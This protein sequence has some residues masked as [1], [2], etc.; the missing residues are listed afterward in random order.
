MRTLLKKADLDAGARRTHANSGATRRRAASLAVS[1][2]VPR[3]TEAGPHAVERSERTFDRALA[4]RLNAIEAPRAAATLGCADNP[5]RTQQLLGFES[6]QG[7]VNRAP[8]DGPLREAF[9][10]IAYRGTS[11]FVLEPERGHEHSQFE[12]AER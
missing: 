10:F 4:G 3:E 9:D 12:L 11:P 8:R 6:I 7:H 2:V 5:A 1:R